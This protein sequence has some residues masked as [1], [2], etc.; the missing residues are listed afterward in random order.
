MNKILTN[1]LSTSI[2]LSVSKKEIS[3]D[4]NIKIDKGLQK[5]LAEIANSEY[6]SDTDSL[7]F[8]ANLIGGYSEKLK[9]DELFRLNNL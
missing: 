6:L 5:Y 3:T 1:V 7:K 9:Y 2:Q 4:K 8:N